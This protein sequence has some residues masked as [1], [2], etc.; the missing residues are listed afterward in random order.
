MLNEMDSA[1]AFFTLWA[2]KRFSCLSEA[3]DWCAEESW[4]T[5]KIRLS[6]GDEF[7]SKIFQGG[8]VMKGEDKWSERSVRAKALQLHGRAL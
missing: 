8:H 5:L 3:S 4:W 7:Y 6:P 2:L 1:T